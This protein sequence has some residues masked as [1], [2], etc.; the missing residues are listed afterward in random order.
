[1]KLV[2]TQQQVYIL[3]YQDFYEIILMTFSE[4][5][6]KPEVDLEYG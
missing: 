3:V 6:G 5:I 4:I 1:M 2:A